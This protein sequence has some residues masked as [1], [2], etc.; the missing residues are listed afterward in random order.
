MFVHGGNI[1]IFG[2][3]WYFVF[4]WHIIYVHLIWYISLYIEQNTAQSTGVFHDIA[5]L[6]M[7][8]IRFT[9]RKHQYYNTFAIFVLP[10]FRERDFPSSPKPCD[11]SD[12][13]GHLHGT[14]CCDHQYN[15]II[16][17]NCMALYWNRWI[18]LESCA[19]MLYVMDYIEWNFCS[20]MCFSDAH[21]YWSH[22]MIAC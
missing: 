2:T 7:I 16:T 15:M 19:F 13:F 20:V 5:Q 17:S 8:S 18:Y 11:I 10:N 12:V 9:S 4:Y 21:F 6:F 22:F 14:F 1:L 3:A